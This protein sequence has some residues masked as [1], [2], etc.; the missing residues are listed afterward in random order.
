MV[1]L[2]IFLGGRYGYLL[3]ERRRFRLDERAHEV[4]HAQPAVVVVSPETLRGAADAS[5]CYMEESD[6]TTWR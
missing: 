1:G 2:V 5:A 6:T 4:A 3:E